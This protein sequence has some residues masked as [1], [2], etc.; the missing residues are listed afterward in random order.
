MSAFVIEIT[1][2]CD[3]CCTDFPRT[4]FRYRQTAEFAVRT[5]ARTPKHRKALRFIESTWSKEEF[6]KHRLTRNRGGG[7]ERY[8]KCKEVIGDSLEISKISSGTRQ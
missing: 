5:C 3:A 1:N 2:D 6:L 7:G 4:S 8:A